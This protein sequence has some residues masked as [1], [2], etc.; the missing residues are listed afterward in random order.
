MPPAPHIYGTAETCATVTCHTVMPSEIGPSSTGWRSTY[1]KRAGEDLH[2][3]VYP[4]APWP[5]GRPSKHGP[6]QPSSGCG[7]AASIFGNFP[8]RTSIIGRS[9]GTSLDTSPRG[10]LRPYSNI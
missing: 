9:D 6:R 2:T 1:D 3:G 5:E 8:V 4:S 10:V 7:R